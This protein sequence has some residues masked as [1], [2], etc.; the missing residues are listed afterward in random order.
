MPKISEC[1]RNDSTFG[2][3]CGKDSVTDH[4]PSPSAGRP[5]GLAGATGVIGPR[6]LAVCGVY[7]GNRK[8]NG[9][10]QLSS[11]GV[12]RYYAHAQLTLARVPP[13]PPPAVL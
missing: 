12:K 10:Q 5:Q 1:G 9:R 3:V 7:S 11:R 4:T 13:P 6:L 2:L 8:W